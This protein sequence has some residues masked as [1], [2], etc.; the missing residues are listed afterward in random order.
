ME[1]NFH[2]EVHLSD[3][4]RQTVDANLQRALRASD[5]HREDVSVKLVDLNGKKG[6][7]D[8]RCKIIARLHWGQSI[9][10]EETE[11]EVLDAVHK[12][13]LHLEE[14]LRRAIEKKQDHRR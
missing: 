4:Q 14:A 9:V 8:K 2:S 10:I 1:F 5:R 7:I 12:A 11:A 6:G 13:A 3:L